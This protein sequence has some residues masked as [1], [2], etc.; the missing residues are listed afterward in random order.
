MH[1]IKGE[2]V[3]IRFGI[4]AKYRSVIFSCPSCS[5][6]ITTMVDPILL[7]NDLLDRLKKPR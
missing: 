2:D 1:Y 7:N 4:N 6:A 5:V 3:E